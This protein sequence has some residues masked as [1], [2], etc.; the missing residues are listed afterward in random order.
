MPARHSSVHLDLSNGAGRVL[1]LAAAFLLAGLV[2]AAE[3][4]PPPSKG[5]EEFKAL[6][7]RLVGPAGG[8]RVSRV[9]GVPGDPLVAY[10][11]TASGGVWK[12][13]DGGIHWKSIFDDQPISS[14][15]SIA[16]APS[17]PGVVYV[18]SGE[19][20]IRGNVAAGNGIY[21]STDAGKTW[22]H[23]WKQE[24]QIGTMVVHPTDSDIA[25]AAVL[26][27]AFGPNPERGVY[28]TTDGGKSWQQV[29]AED[30]DTGASDVCLDRAHPNVIFAGFWQA[31]R[32]AWSLTSGG[33][34][35]GLHVSRDG[36]DTWKALT[37]HG[38]PEGNWGKV[39]CA[40]APSDSRRVYALI[41][42]EKGGLF[43][44]D[45]GGDTWSLVSGHHALTQRAWYYSTMTVDPRNPDV[46]WFPQVP[47]L[48]SVDGGRSIRRVK[49]P[50]H[51]DHHDI[52]ID[53][54]DSRRVLD[55][56][57]G[58]VD[59][60]WNGGETWFSPELPIGQLYHIATD[61]S[62]PYRISG[63]MQDLGTAAC[64]SN[65]L[66]SGGIRNADCYDIGGGEA[67]FTVHDPSDPNIVWA[68][69]YQ[70]ILTRFDNRTG[71]VRPVSAYPESWSGH[72]AADARFR[73]QWTAPIAMSPHDPKVVYHGGNVL[74]RTDDGGQTWKAI[75]P[76]LTR[77]DKEKQAWSG[78]PI[79]GDNTG[80]EFYGTIF[81]V[82]ESPRAKGLLWAGT[83]DGRVHVSRDGGGDWTE[84]T[85]RLK[86]FPEWGTVS[87]IEPSPHEEGTAYVV[88]DA[89]R[90]DDM[91]P[92]LWR[93]TDYG[94][95]WK[96]LAGNLPQDVYLHAVR[97]D[98]KRKGLLFL[99]TERG[100]SFSLDNGATWR[101]LGLNL[102]TVAVHDLA[103]HGDDLVVG[104]HGRGAWILDDLTPIREWS[105]EAAGRPAHLFSS[106]PAV[107]WEY[108][109][110]F[111]GSGPGENPPRGATLQYFLKAKPKEELRLEIVDAAGSVVRTF[112]SAPAPP[113]IAEDDPDAGGRREKTVLSTEPGVQRVVWNL[114]VEPARKIPDAKVE[115]NP[116]DALRVLPGK[117]VARLTADGNTLTT[118][119]EVL[120]DPR[121]PLPA[122]AAE[123]LEFVVR[124][125][126]QVTRLSDLVAQIRSVR[127]QLQ[128]KVSALA[129][130]AKASGWADGAKGTIA[131]LTALEG[132]IHNPE[133]EVDYD[134][135]AKGI[136][137]YS[138]VSTLLSI[139]TDGT[140]APTQGMREV[141]A[142]QV[143]KGD[144]L[145]AEW[146]TL[147]SQDL[148]T[149]ARQARQSGIEAVVVPNPGGP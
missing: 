134:I 8:G 66:H 138:Q 25:F 69:E 49:G 19:A 79:T 87:L 20:N 45:D 57:D 11:A 111:S 33:P 73:F 110:V 9:A 105:E 1:G 86:G 129:G 47:L 12:S 97:E 41:E 44:S 125:Q 145:A 2:A 17:D 75:S 149:L 114:E 52:W 107:R 148:A 71:M 136:R 124:I 119:I 88:V 122:G 26:G 16:V 28:R 100:V 67:G 38:L 63:A 99:G 13:E 39:G 118:P 55:A 98:P 14:I 62:T 80:A 106:R 130:D 4:A 42:A 92:Y 123:Q 117:Y 68:G 104:T 21:K 81:A 147:V 5:P 53:P 82:A 133:A 60:S 78:G 139:A 37:G 30:A 15:G 70:G 83:D 34:G 35:S 128:A 76:D 7:Y 3:S 58:G 113:A 59:L 65:S 36:G 135:L 40:V 6:K 43:R 96:S 115:G 90:L 10:A 61:A 137:L 95:S 102:P 89:H 29:L 91:R 144:A 112:T 64:P 143:Q 56:N 50:H 120:P 121:Q 48:R 24:G 140:G 132:K 93:T 72:G 101:P 84:V 18:G 108:R 126:A 22:A 142:D 54:T 109:A 32:T 116:E 77:N 74:F 94:K 85:A 27:H 31:R 103:V 51:G 146:G 23:V 46:V 127:E 141:F 131:R